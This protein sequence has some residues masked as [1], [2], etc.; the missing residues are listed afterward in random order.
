MT[1]AELL[2]LVLMLLAVLF[3]NRTRRFDH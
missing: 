1:P 2:F 3:G